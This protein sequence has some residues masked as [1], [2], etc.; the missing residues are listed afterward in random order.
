[1]KK[2]SAEWSEAERSILL[3]SRISELSYTQS[4]KKTIRHVVVKEKAIIL[5]LSLL[6]DEDNESDEVALTVATFLD[7][8][9]KHRFWIRQHIKYHSVHGEFSTY[10]QTC[11]D[12]MF[13]TSYRVSR[14]LFYELHYHLKP[15]LWFRCICR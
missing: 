7:L 11:D 6:E 12:E 15:Y 1:M 3:E 4:L 8:K 13:E 10:F 2:W 9:R 5:Y 14:K